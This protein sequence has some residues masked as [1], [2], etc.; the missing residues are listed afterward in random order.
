MQPLVEFKIASWQGPFP[1]DLQAAATDALESG[2]VL[3][4]PGLAFPPREDEKALF[5]TSFS[6][7]RKNLTFDPATGRVHGAA[8]EASE[9]GRLSRMLGRYGENVRGLCRGLFP[10]FGEA[11]ELARTT[12]RP[13]E[14]L[15][16]EYSPRSDDRRLHVD[17][18][19]SRPSHGR[20]ILRVF[21]NVNP[22]GEPRV[23]NVGEDFETFA[24]KF[25]PRARRQWPLEARALEILNVTK[26]RRGLYDHLMLQLHDGGKLD[27]GY[28]RDAPKV[29]AAFPPDTTWMCFTDQVLHAALSGRFAL[30]QTL[31]LDPAKQKFPERAPVRVLERLTGRALA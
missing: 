12:F 13:T 16:R 6:G 11:L 20:R 8:L 25:L 18:F 14:I 24:R 9:H 5:S 28:Q 7:E 17:A 3:V 31:H 19:P 4:F 1:E 2:K 15:G 29:R 22:A 21:N 23:W 27:E 30:E 10:D 26:G